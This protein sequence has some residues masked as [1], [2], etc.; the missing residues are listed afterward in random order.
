LTARVKTANILAL[1]QGRFHTERNTQCTQYSK[2]A[3]SSIASLKAM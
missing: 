1:L 3:E 2:P